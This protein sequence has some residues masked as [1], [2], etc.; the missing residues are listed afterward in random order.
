MSGNEIMISG[1]EFELYQFLFSS[2]HSTELKE[3]LKN[4]HL[5][6]LLQ[7]VDTADNSWKAISAAMTEPLFLE[8]ADE[9]LKIIEPD[10]ENVI[11][12]AE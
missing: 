7:E 8:F 2:G 1:L 4:P 11:S 3:I 6:S 5:R 9:V 10:N 12:T